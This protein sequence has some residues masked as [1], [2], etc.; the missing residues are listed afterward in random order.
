ML[1]IFVCDDEL[2]YRNNLTKIIKNYLLN[3]LL[4][5]E[6][7]VRFQFSTED[8]MTILSYISEN[9]TEGIYFLDI[10]LN[11]TLNGIEL[12]KKIREYDPTAKII[13]VT[14][15]ADLAYLTF[16][17]K[18]EALDYIV[19]DNIETLQKKVIDCID[20]ALKRYLNTTLE[21]RPHIWIK[22]GPTDIKLYVDEILYFESSHTPHKL[23]VHLDNRMIEFV[24]KIKEVEQLNDSFCRC[25]QS[26][27]VN[28]TNIKEINRK[29]RVITMI[30]GE[31][32]LIS[33]RYLKKLVKNFEEKVK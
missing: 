8:P 23:I 29:E 30:N 10:D 21:T 13:F 6:Y 28:L 9:K 5:K 22:S 18:V 4:M 20:I 12:G 1:K 2:V 19:K 32:C 27:V 16:I 15:Y 33:T 14:S 25:H 7:D 24:G 31:K 17:Y 3:Y 26:F 11:S